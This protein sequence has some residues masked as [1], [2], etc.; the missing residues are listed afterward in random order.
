ML[1][2]SKY[3]TQKCREVCEARGFYDYRFIPKRRRSGNYED[4]CYCLT[5]EEAQIKNR[6]V[7][8]TRVY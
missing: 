4:R 2:D 6:I 3:N 5:E 8:G 1:L 7:K